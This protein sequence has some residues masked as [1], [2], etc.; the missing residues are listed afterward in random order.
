MIV[1]KG[2][3]E[4]LWVIGL[5]IELW[6]KQEK[7]VLYYDSMSVIHLAKDQIYHSKTKY[8]DV[9]YHWIWDFV[10][11]EKINLMKT[12]TKDNAADMITKIVI[13]KKFTHCLDFD[14][15]CSFQGLV[16]PPLPI[17]MGHLK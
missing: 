9:R 12:P 11:D 3:K 7:L 15:S 4:T 16:E 8:I 1:I 10:T 5:V 6:L 14:Q 17:G 13:T 2:A